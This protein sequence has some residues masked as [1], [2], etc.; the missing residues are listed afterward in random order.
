MS[1]HL[2]I[3]PEQVKPLLGKHILRDGYDLVM[4][5]QRSHGSYVYD[6]LH[7]RELLD[8]F[9]CF[10]TIPIGYNH[11]KMVLDEAFR[12]QLLWAAM[13][14]PTNSDIY[15]PQYAQFIETFGRIGIPADLPHVFLIAGGALAVENALKVAMDWKVQK[16]FAKGHVVEKGHKVL[17]FQ[18]AFHGRSGYTLSLTNTDPGKTRYFAK[19]TDWP[20]VSNPKIIFPLTP[21]RE[22]D[23]FR[24]EELALNQIRMAF[25]EHP[26]DISAVIIEPIQSEGGDNHFRPE[27][28]V[29]LKQLCL[30]HEA[31][32]IYDEVQV[33]VGAT[34][35]FWSFEQ[36]GPD[37]RPDIVAFG[38]KMQI[39]GI[40]AGT[41]VD[42]VEHN[43][44]TVSSRINS[45]WGGNLVDM[46]RATRILQI[47]EEDRILEH[48]QVTGRY[49]LEQLQVVGAQFPGLV[50][51]VRGR[52]FILAFDLP[53]TELRNRF[54]AEGMAQNV[55]FLGCGTHS[56]RFRPTLTMSKAEI[57]RG[58]EIIEDVLHKLK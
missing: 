23:L 30:E 12:E 14:N 29:R 52:G 50:S 9:S 43:C 6:A 56:I 13:G 26:D 1:Y 3:G 18:E 57:D 41:R 40:L 36:F 24:R 31:L 58:I 55:M 10:A 27:F 34:G 44:F 7:N 11:P 53:S 8:F 5:L 33:G 38:K 16:N 51:N 22:R 35:T 21:E 37:A 25:R 28:F 47:I 39:C 54:I 46:V 45:T 42:E 32:L 48:V 2:T 20:R 17:H 15:T 4:D 49:F 19:F